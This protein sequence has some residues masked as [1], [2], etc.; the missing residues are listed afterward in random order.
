MPS[1]DQERL[2]RFGL[3]WAVGKMLGPIPTA[4]VVVAFTLR[5]LGFPAPGAAIAVSGFIGA[6]LGTLLAA[7]R[8]LG[9]RAIAL[10]PTV[11]LLLG[12]QSLCGA[13]LWWFGVPAPG[14]AG[15]AAF[16]MIAGLALLAPLL[17]LWGHGVVAGALAGCGWLWLV[18]P[19][20]PIAAV[21]LLALILSEGGSG[22][23]SWRGAL[24]GPAVGLVLGHL[25]SVPLLR[26]LFD[27]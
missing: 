11:P 24:A 25:M 20:W 9:H 13:A 22:A 26:L 16:A 5:F 23:R 14:T 2:P 21:C 1:Y 7:D 10:Y 18:P 15:F 12:A 8:V 6:A 3:A 4:V 27:T 19:L 17:G